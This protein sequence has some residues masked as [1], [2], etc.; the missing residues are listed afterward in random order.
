MPGDV[1]FS[2][3]HRTVSWCFPVSKQDTAAKG[4]W[5]THGCSCA[6]A[7]EGRNLLCPVC[8]MKEAVSGDGKLAEELKAKW[9]EFPLFATE[10]G[11][12]TEKLAIAH[13]CASATCPTSTW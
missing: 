11:Q 13:T 9:A 3:E 5:R 6:A 1:T 12:H 10:Q 7:E 2:A 4:K 8:G